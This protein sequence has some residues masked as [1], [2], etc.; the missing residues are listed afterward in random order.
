M[1]APALATTITVA[2][3]VAG[4]G[5]TQNSPSPG[6]QKPPSAVGS[7]G[8]HAHPQAIDPVAGA[9]QSPPADASAPT[10]VGVDQ[11][12]TQLAQPVSDAVIRKELA[13][14]LLPGRIVTG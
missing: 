4:C 3:L 9:A 2:A 1:R 6:A 5:Q 10:Q 11:S 8:L 13:A 7:L 12:G 14:S